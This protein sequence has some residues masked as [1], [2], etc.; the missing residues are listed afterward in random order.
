MGGVGV[1][2]VGALK[3]LQ[4]NRGLAINQKKFLYE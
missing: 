3:S 2:G 1:E 4:S